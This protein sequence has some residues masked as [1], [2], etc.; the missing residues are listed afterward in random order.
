MLQRAFGIHWR[1]WWI[2]L[3]FRRFRLY[4]EDYSRVK[5]W[6]GSVSFNV[7]NAVENA[8]Q[9]EQIL[10]LNRCSNSAVCSECISFK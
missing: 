3:I 5:E 7:Y 2:L 4:R 6:E 9:F 8:T 1:E 10:P